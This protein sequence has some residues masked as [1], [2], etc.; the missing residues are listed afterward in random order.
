M[1]TMLY[2]KEENRR[3][4]NESLIDFTLIYYSYYSPTQQISIAYIENPFLMNFF[5][6]LDDISE[7]WQ[8]ESLIHANRMYKLISFLFIL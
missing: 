4:S 1:M 7:K 3:E 2:R 6:N 5:E 8:V